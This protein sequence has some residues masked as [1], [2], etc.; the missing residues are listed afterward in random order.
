MAS[1]FCLTI[2]IHDSGSVSLVFWL[3]GKGVVRFETQQFKDTAAA[4]LDV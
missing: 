4:R 3:M 2:S 1:T